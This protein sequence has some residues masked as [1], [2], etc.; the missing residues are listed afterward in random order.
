MTNLRVD[1]RRA[2]LCRRPPAEVWQQ[3][4]T[5]P[6]LAASIPAVRRCEQVG[7]RWRWEFDRHGAMGFEVV[8]AFD[9][10]ATFEEPHLVTIRPVGEVSEDARGVGHVR[11]S[12][13]VA[14]TR[15]A[16]EV[17]LEVDVPVPRLLARPLTAVMQH[18][19]GR[20][21]DDFLARLA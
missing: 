4:G 9:V 5:V 17:H 21:I 10:L 13:S 20:V 11:L 19:V 1:V 15:V 18:E 6:D 8:P 2:G 14:G 16:V 7:D 12:P 3:V